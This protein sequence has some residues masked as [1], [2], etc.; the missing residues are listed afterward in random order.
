M[1]A[2][3]YISNRL[4]L[5]KRFNFNN[6]FY[7]YDLIYNKITKI[8]KAT[9]N[10]INVY[11]NLGKNELL[12]K[13]KNQYPKNILKKSINLL[14]SIFRNDFNKNAYS[15]KMRIP[16]PARIK[17]TLEGKIDT[18]TF[19]VSDLC[20]LNCK[21]CPY[22]STSQIFN[23]KR[24]LMTK[25]MAKQGVIFL[26]KHSKLS[27]N[28]TIS[29]SGGEPLINLKTIKYI[30]N[31]TKSY[32]KDKK[33]SFNI[34]TNA[35]LLNKQS[36]LFFIKNYIKLIISLDGPQQINDR[37]RF[38]KSGN[39]TFKI[40]DE[41]I[42]LIRHLSEDYF[43]KAVTFNTVSTR[44]YKIEKLYDFFF[45]KYGKITSIIPQTQQKY[46]D[47]KISTEIKN[48]KHLSGE[49]LK[50]L[51][52]KSLKNINYKYLLYLN[53][54]A[55]ELKL[56]SERRLRKLNKYIPP[57]G[58]CIPGERVSIAPD[59][60]LYICYQLTYDLSI[61]DIFKGFNFYNILKILRHYK[62][63][64]QNDCSSCW[65]MRFCK[66]CLFHLRR[67]KNSDI[68]FKRKNCKVFKSSLVEG[69]KLA[70]ALSTST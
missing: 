44:N 14:D 7:I 17:K 8:N 59:G 15:T 68:K 27:K 22:S 35:T 21:Y 4:K 60:K 2:Q 66:L 48:K 49:I 41:K 11:F 57:N 1:E 32:L 3:K 47:K 30:V 12:K 61:G 5:I 38:T 25:N 42:S 9:Y 29:F 34:T 52:I 6:N 54:F 63:A 51:K 56:I 53:F 64:S 19:F 40:I 69:L 36:V 67:N 45:E 16:L 39:G 46:T 26:K 70:A 24:R 10:I 20:N 28:L 58:M 50:N 18:A 23:E 65:A 37:N 43:Q 33:I 31:L 55:Q 62:T 13:F